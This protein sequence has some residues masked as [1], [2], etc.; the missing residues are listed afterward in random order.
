MTRILFCDTNII[1]YLLDE[2]SR[3][4]KFIRHIEDTESTF[5]L[6]LIQIVELV[7]LP[8]YHSPLADLILATDAHIFAW[9]KAIVEEE[10][11]RYP[12]REAVDPLSH[13]SLASHY[14]GA[15]GRSQ[16]ALALAGDDLNVLWHEF[17]DQ[18]IRYMPVMDWLPSTLPSSQSE[19]A[20]D[21][22]FQVHNFGFVMGALREISP[23]LV[24]KIE[25]ELDALDEE[26]FPGAYLHA[27]YTYYRYIL[28]GMSPRPSDVLDVHQVFYI[29]YCWKA[30]IEKS[31]AGILHQLKSER[32]LLNDVE[33]QTIRH[34]RSLFGR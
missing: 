33:I 29:P 32:G 15:S 6:S 19:G 21:L 1:R 23:G 5:V 20:I 30:I 12:G 11:D 16:L 13:P 14:R 27:A 17:E 8:R 22:D 26:A 7:K 2:S 10:A 31:M 9:W 25:P 24:G 28:K 18:K 3:I 34:A 4:P